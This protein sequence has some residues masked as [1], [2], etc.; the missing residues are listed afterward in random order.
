MLKEDISVESKADAARAVVEEHAEATGNANDDY[1]AQ[2]GDLLAN[3]M[4]LCQA[5]G[6]D[7]AGALQTA[8]MHFEHEGGDGLACFDTGEDVTV[9]MSSELY[10]S[11]E[12]SY[13]SV[14]EA[15]AG[16][17]RLAERVRAEDDGVEREIVMLCPFDGQVGDGAGA[18]D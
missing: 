16:M 15:L 1:A 3:V 6:V 10:G 12:F 17:R 5:E 11:E 9:R 18:S 4:H 7:F 2:V 14:A 13:G 8:R